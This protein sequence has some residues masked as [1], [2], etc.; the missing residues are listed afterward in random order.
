MSVTG[1]SVTDPERNT[2]MQPPT[3]ASKGPYKI[4]VK[5]ISAEGTCPNG[6][7]V[8]DEWDIV[9]KTPERGICL[10]AF[11]NLITPIRIL[12]TGGSYPMYPEQD[13]YQTCCPDIRNKLLFEIRRS[14]ETLTGPEGAGQRPRH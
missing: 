4:T 14:P 11:C 8:G 12:E 1:N 2:Y 7:Q 9:R 13:S 5:V 10:A 6:H 3:E